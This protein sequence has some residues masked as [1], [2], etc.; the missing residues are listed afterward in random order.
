[1]NIIH[2]SHGR[3]EE[4]SAR[5]ANPSYLHEMQQI[6]ASRSTFVLMVSITD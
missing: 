5:D 6:Y 1:M 3:P 4:S 2:H